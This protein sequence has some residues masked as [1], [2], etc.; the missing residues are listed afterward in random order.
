[1][2][3]IIFKILDAVKGFPGIGYNERKKAKEKA[4]QVYYAN[5][6][7]HDPKEKFILGKEAKQYM[8]VFASKNKRIKYPQFHAIVSAKGNSSNQDEL[9][10]IGLNIMEKMGYSQNP[11]LV[12]LHSDTKHQHP[13]IISARID[14][15]GKK[16][17]DKFEGI[18]ANNIL[19]KLLNIHQ[20]E[21]Y[22]KDISEVLSYRAATIPQ[23]QLLFE[24]RGYSV[25]KSA[26]GLKLFKYG[27]Q[28]GAVTALELQQARTIAYKNDIARIRALLYKYKKVHSSLLTE[29]NP[30]SF[31][32][33]NKQPGSELTDYMHRLFGLQ[34]AFFTAKGH[35]KPYGYAIIDHKNK[36]VYKGS[37]IMKLD[38][39]ISEKPTEE[40]MITENE[41][42]SQPQNQNQSKVLETSA[43]ERT[44]NERQPHQPD[45]KYIP[46]L[47]LDRMIQNIEHEAEKDI[48]KEQDAKKRR[49]GRFI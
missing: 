45:D 22:K 48:H 38:Q 10:Q 15:A 44:P 6:P 33:H 31:E 7:Y 13:H 26:D 16:I 39:L 29:R 32:H 21:N 18:R 42:D 43:E 24:L 46:D 5:F 17:P 35:D 2:S 27:T 1:M 40:K 36:V 37:E 9:L 34:F 25:Q 19:T 41:K 8:E 3:R 4:R 20:E 47:P 14:A 23:Y 11:T 28:Q 49:K 12:Y 30:R